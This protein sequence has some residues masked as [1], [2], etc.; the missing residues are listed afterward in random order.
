MG[1]VHTTFLAGLCALTGAPASGCG[2]F[3]QDVFSQGRRSAAE[4]LARHTGTACSAM[5]QLSWGQ[6]PP[7][8]QRPNQVP[9]PRA[10]ESPA[11]V[12]AKFLAQCTLDLSLLKFPYW[13]ASGR[14][15][16]NRGGQ[17]SYIE[18]ISMEQIQDFNVNISFVRG[19]WGGG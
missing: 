14:V 1:A 10:L 4:A 8:P 18:V 5:T 11:C 13:R 17:G 7:P 19:T 6:D 16:K 12:G 9:A 15:V 3:L 2:C